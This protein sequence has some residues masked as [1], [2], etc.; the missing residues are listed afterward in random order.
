MLMPDVYA[1][2]APRYVISF[3]PVYDM[4]MLLIYTI[5]FMLIFSRCAISALIVIML[6]PRAAD[7]AILRHCVYADIFRHV[8]S[9]CRRAIAMMPSYCYCLRHTPIRRRHARAIP[10]C[11]FT[12]F[13]F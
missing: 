2:I 4:M 7:A 8:S 11:L 13:T 1:M 3:A 6:L 9:A 10:P 5:I 12:M